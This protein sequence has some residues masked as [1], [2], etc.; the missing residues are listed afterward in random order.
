MRS[1]F[2][3]TSN[4]APFTRLVFQTNIPTQKYTLF[5]TILVP[6]VECLTKVDLV[7]QLV[8]HADLAVEIRR[9]RDQPLQRASI[10]Q[11]SKRKSETAKD[12][13]LARLKE[14][15]HKLEQRVRAL[16]QENEVLYGKLAARE[17]LS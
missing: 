4:S 5:L 16:Q 8:G 15:V 13:Q 7:A 1:L 6:E 14:R 12:A 17:C 9:L 10:V 3:A 11:P 2:C